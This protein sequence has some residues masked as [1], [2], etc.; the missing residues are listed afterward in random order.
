MKGVGYIYKGQLGN[1]DLFI[2]PS[3]I[4]GTYV[5]NN[6]T[7]K[8]ISIEVWCE[9]QPNLSK[10][11]VITKSEYWPGME[12]EGEFDGNKMTYEFSQLGKAKIYADR[13]DFGNGIIWKKV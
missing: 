2:H 10:L 12:V 3:M 11:N 4:S 6:D 1:D 5:Y 9:E 7:T 8:P 13:L